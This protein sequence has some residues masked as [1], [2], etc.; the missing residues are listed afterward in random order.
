[1]AVGINSMVNSFLARLTCCTSIP[2]DSLLIS[3][4]TTA[5]GGL[6]LTDASAR[7]ILDFSLT[8]S[9]TIRHTEE[10]FSFVSHTIP[11]RLHNTLTD[12]FNRQLN[13][14]PPSSDISTAY[15][16]MSPRLTLPN[17]AQTPST[18]SGENM[19]FKS[20]RDCLKQEANRLHHSSHLTIASPSLK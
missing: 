13:P 18:T 3:Y 8:M 9:Q 14:L 6:R 20:T 2:Q 12:L 16:M 11:Y 17:N 5:Q 15:F 19:S 4:M 7:A 1:M 10:G